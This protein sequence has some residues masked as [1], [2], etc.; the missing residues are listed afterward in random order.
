M[1][2]PRRLYDV[3]CIDISKMNHLLLQG[4]RAVHLWSAQSS[5][6]FGHGMLGSRT[7][8]NLGTHC[9]M[10]SHAPPP[11]GRAKVLH[12]LPLFV[13][14]DVLSISLCYFSFYLRPAR[15]C[16]MTNFPDALVAA[17]T[18]CLGTGR[19]TMRSS[20]ITSGRRGG[21]LEGAAEA[22]CALGAELD[23]V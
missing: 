9:A 10:D 8:D 19:A 15:N 13:L 16:N 20:A 5:H 21:Y 14:H 23:A 22:D 12:R 7:Q 3:C 6:Q 4:G 11:A 18:S 2:V 17:G 1:V